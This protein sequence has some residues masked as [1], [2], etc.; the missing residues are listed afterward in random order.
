MIVK[1]GAGS[2]RQTL[3]NIP[4]KYDHPFLEPAT[5]RCPGDY[6]LQIK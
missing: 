3:E 1:L 6:L 4:F 2:K 5:C